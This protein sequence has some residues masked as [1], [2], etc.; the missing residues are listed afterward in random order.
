MSAVE[1]KRPF[2]TALRIGSSAN[3]WNT[4]GPIRGSL[5]YINPNTLVLNAGSATSFTAV[6]LSSVCPPNATSTLLNFLQVGAGTI[7]G[8][9]KT[10]QA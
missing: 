6:D 4:A 8:W 2:V 10:S 5:V 7:S 9:V 1:V 3:T